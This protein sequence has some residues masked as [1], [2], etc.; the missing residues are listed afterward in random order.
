MNSKTCKIPNAL[1]EITGIPKYEVL[2]EQNNCLQT[3]IEQLGEKLEN[4][5]LIINKLTNDLSSSKTQF[6]EFTKNQSNSFELFAQT[7]NQALDHNHKLFENTLSTYEHWTI[8]LT[9]LI[10][11]AGIF[12]FFLVKNYKQREVNQVV[13]EAVKSAKE[14]LQD[15]DLVKSAVVNALATAESQNLI[16]KTVFDIN[17]SSQPEQ[18]AT[19]EEIDS[20]NDVIEGESK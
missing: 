14:K 2:K 10:A 19:L 8:G 13:D 7:Q 9:I 15:A 4:Q 12:G 6:N 5:Q 20:L 18:Q 17:E 11:I 3:Q 16:K 1:H